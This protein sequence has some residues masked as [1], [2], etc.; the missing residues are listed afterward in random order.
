MCL[1]YCTW[2]SF[3]VR[4]NINAINASMRFKFM[5]SIRDTNK[6]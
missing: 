6:L 2:V 3:E 1:D 5:S 4:Y